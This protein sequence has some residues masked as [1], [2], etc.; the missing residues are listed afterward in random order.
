MCLN[1]SSDLRVLH[2]LSL[3]KE[4]LCPGNT[5]M[6]L[7]MGPMGNENG[8]TI[9]TGAIWHSACQPAEQW[10]FLQTQHARIKTWKQNSFYCHLP[11]LGMS[12][13]LG[14][15]HLKQ[16]IP[17]SGKKPNPHCITVGLVQLS[18]II[19][20]AH[21]GLENAGKA[22]WANSTEVVKKTW[23]QHTAAYSVRFTWSSLTCHLTL[24]VTIEKLMLLEGSSSC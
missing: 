23:Q 7:K 11:R 8:K 15:D 6:D 13:L 19:C 20:Y 3:D 22:E 24:L 12:P 10:C 16:N 2:L 14:L 9:D 17:G 21:G 5:K 4:V 18:F 1:L